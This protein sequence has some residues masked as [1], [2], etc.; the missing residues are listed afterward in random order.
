[1]VKEPPEIWQERMV[2]KIYY[3]NFGIG[4]IGTNSRG[5]NNGLSLAKYLK[6]WTAWHRAVENGKLE[7]L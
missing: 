6:E 5:V 1:M 7:E 3:R 2:N 4:I